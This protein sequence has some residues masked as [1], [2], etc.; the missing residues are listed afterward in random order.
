MKKSSFLVLALAVA[1]FTSCK[2]VEEPDNADFA[3]YLNSDY[4][5][6]LLDLSKANE[7]PYT[8]ELSD[9]IC[10]VAKSADANSYVVWAGDPGHTFDGRNLADSLLKDT[11]NNASF[12][13]A[14]TALSATDG[15]GRKYK[16]YKYSAISPVGEPFQVYCTARNYDYKKGEYA[17]KVY[18]PKSIV[19]VDSKVDL[20]NDADPYNSAGPSTYDITIIYKNG[21]KQATITNKSTGKNGSYELV[22][23]KEGVTPGV[24][25]TMPKGIPTSAVTKI[26]IKAGNCILF[27][28]EGLVPVNAKKVYGWTPDFSSSTKATVYLKS[29]S[30]AEDAKPGDPYTKGYEFTV[31]E[32]AE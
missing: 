28:E 17:E 20:W 25:I 30:A 27:T 9:Q 16:T 8:I 15:K 6:N 5:A 10:F 22:Y 26:N 1:S 7:C 32:Y 21:S 2:H 13:S 11:V 18:G 19:V 4:S 3:W 23:E 14:G 31:V 29:Q 12:R 24:K